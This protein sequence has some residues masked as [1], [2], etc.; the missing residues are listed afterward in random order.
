MFESLEILTNKNST[1]PNHQSKKKK[2][3]FQDYCSRTEKFKNWFLKLKLTLE[4]EDFYFWFKK[5]YYFYNIQLYTYLYYDAKVYIYVSVQ[6]WQ[7][8]GKGSDSFH[9][10]TNFRF[11]YKLYNIDL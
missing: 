2:D 3:F 5:N 9:K 10:D 8:N 6:G 7:T 1:E 4:M 11:K